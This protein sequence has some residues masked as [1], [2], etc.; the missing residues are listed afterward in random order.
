MKQLKMK[1]LIEKSHLITLFIMKNMIF[2]KE[3]DGQIIFLEGWYASYKKLPDPLVNEIIKYYKNKTELKGVKG[4]EIEYEL[5][6]QLINACY[7][8]MVQSSIKAQP[9]FKQI[10]EWDD[11][12]TKIKEDNSLTN[13]EKKKAIEELERDLLGKYN[14]KA[15]LAYQWGVWCTSAARFRLFQGIKL[16]HGTGENYANFIYCDT[17]SVKYIGDID[18]SE[19]NNAR[20]AECRESGAF[21]TDPA[22]ITHYMGVFES[23]DNSDTGFAYYSFKTLGAKKYAYTKTKDGSTY[24]TIAGVNKAKGGKE[25]DDHGGLKAF[26]DGFVFKE[27]GGTEAVYNDDPEIK[28][29]NI[30][31]HILPIISNIAILPSEYTLGITGEYERIIKY[32]K[33]Y[34]ANPYVI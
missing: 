25:L 11:S 7:G 13:E 1:Q 8:M 16:A 17:D 30:D 2:E 20:I 34:L 33:K 15:F 22:G 4:K 24:C 21:A 10:G 5:S 28:S 31:G 27:A 29:V 6:K 12:Y 3:Y 26:E 19:Y 14:K 23:E 9:I 32:S 18:W